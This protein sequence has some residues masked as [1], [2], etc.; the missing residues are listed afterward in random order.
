MGKIDSNSYDGAIR[1]EKTNN[2]KIDCDM[3]SV[4]IKF[5]K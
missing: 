4:R 2:L 5:G 1:S 3:G